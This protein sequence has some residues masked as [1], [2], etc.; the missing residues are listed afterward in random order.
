MQVETYRH[1]GGE[2][3]ITR[4]HKVFGV[5][6]LRMPEYVFFGL[7]E[8]EGKTLEERQGIVGYVEVAQVTME[9]YLDGMIQRWASNIPPQSG[10]KISKV[11]VAASHSR[12]LADTL[13]MDTTG[14][15]RIPR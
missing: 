12:P 14:T 2:V 13:G 1:E 3:V 8:E 9:E 10:V 15:G 7:C 5:C 11:K 6:E 4:N